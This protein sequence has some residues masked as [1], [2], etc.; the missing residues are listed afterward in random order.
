MIE[1]ISGASK[2]S[3]HD[4]ETPIENPDEP[5]VLHLFG[6]IMPSER[7]FEQMLGR[8]LVRE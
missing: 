7:S 2:K 5:G 1:P 3:A 8:S 6:S 4:A